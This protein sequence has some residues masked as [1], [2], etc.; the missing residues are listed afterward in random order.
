[1]S[2]PNKP[3]SLKAI[4]GN[5]GKRALNKNEPDPDYLDNLE[6]PAWLPED[7]KT[8]W[9]ELAFPLR[10]ARVLTVLDVVALSK[11]CVSIANY[12]RAV[13]ACG[14]DLLV[15]A[16]KAKD[17]DAKGKPS[18]ARGIGFTAP[19]AMAG[20]VAGEAPREGSAAPAV[21]APAL[22][23]VMNPWLIVQ[24]MSFKQA[25]TVLREFGM[26]PAARARVMI[27]PQLG[28]FP[29]GEGDKYFT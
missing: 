14:Q 8:V 11:A 23:Q 26:T 7:A 29:R 19:M 5:R 28:L 18:S 3:T 1:M 9:R 16:S 13:Q 25:M 10:K 21:E 20:A 15:S 2:R 27:D 12:R 17:G 6:P 4:E 24:A 22:G